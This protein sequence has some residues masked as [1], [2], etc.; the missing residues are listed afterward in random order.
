MHI[1]RNSLLLGNALSGKCSATQMVG[2][3][4]HNMFCLYI[5]KISCIALQL[6]LCPLI[7]HWF[8]DRNESSRQGFKEEK[9]CVEAGG[10]ELVKQT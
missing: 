1:P 7:S 5:F 2:E 4:C 6:S 10:G 8:Y 3:E 9:E